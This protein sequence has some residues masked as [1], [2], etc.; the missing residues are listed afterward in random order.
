MSFIHSIFYLFCLTESEPVQLSSSHE[1]LENSDKQN[2]GS[3][4]TLTDAARESRI[5]E[6]IIIPPQLR[7]EKGNSKVMSSVYIFYVMNTLSGF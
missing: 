4:N 1:Q 3:A 6:P 2:N 7:E 5:R